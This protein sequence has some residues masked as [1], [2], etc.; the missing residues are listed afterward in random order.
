MR[1]TSSLPR[2]AMP[3]IFVPPRSIPIRMSQPRR[4][5]RQRRSRKHIYLVPFVIF[6][7]SWLINVVLPV[8]SPAEDPPAERAQPLQHVMHVAQVHHLDQVAVEVPGEEKHV[9]AR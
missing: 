2:I 3:S 1:A 9:A 7:P 8:H 4:T 6:A 5:R